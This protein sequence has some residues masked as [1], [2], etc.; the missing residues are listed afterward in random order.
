[1]KPTMQY[2]RDQILGIGLKVN[3][4]NSNTRMYVKACSRVGEPRNLELIYK[5]GATL[6][7][8]LR[9]QDLNL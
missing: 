9:G 2:D 6:K 5:G 3:V 7:G 8:W 1:M 4:C